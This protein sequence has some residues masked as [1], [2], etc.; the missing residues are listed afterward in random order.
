MKGRLRYVV[1][2]V[3]LAFFLFPIAWIV[4]TSF[5]VPEEFL[6]HPPKWIPKRPTLTHYISV[7]NLGGIQSS[8][9]HPGNRLLRH[10]DF[11]RLR[12]T[13]RV[14]SGSLQRRGEESPSLVPLPS[15]APSYN[16]GFSGVSALP[17]PGMD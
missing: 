14:Q 5:K 4:L 15:H 9:K 13:V 16:G 12:D 8:E 3:A 2:T 7:S 1:L 10:S 11:H 17:E 6:A